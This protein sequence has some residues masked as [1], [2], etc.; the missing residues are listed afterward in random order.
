MT[1]RDD[2]KRLADELVAWSAVHGPFQLTASKRE[3]ALSAL[4]AASVKAGEVVAWRYRFITSEQRDWSDWFIVDDPKSIPNRP[5]PDLEIQPLYTTPTAS[6]GAMR[7]ALELALQ[8]RPTL[9]EA[10]FS[11]WN[12]ASSANSA[13]AE[14]SAIEQTIKDALHKLE[15]E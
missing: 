2:Y 13:A 8:L 4:R 12:D 3:I 1:D 9:H 14:A 15:V 10:W 5:L 7:E 6:V 11:N